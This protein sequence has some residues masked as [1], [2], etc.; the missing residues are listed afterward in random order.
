MEVGE[1]REKLAKLLE[2]DGFYIILFICVCIV[3]VTAVITSKGNLSKARNIAEKNEDELIIL[4]NEPDEEEILQISKRV[5]E[6][7][8]DV[9]AEEEVEAVKEEPKEEEVTEETNSKEEALAKET[10]ATSKGES[11]FEMVAPVNGTVGTAYSEDKLVYSETLEEW[12]AHR[13]V[14]IMADE[15]TLVV[16]ALSGTVQEVYDDPLWGKVVIIDHG[17]D[18]LTK[19]ANLSQDV[20][21]QEGVKV[22]KGDVIGK[23]GKTAKIEMLMKPHLHFEVIENGISVNPSKYLSSF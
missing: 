2:K 18:L 16:A 14:D 17:N 4:D 20:S 15:G 21:V 11:S 19:Y 1:L 7:K 8:E 12:T 9:N 3:A 23:I 13:G 10:M 6:K 22:G 5:E